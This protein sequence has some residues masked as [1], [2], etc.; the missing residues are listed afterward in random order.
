MRHTLTLT[1]R[2]FNKQNPKGDGEFYN[3]S[4]FVSTSQMK[5]FFLI[6]ASENVPVCITV[7]EKLMIYIHDV[8]S[9]ISY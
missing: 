2:T 7:D 3:K 4:H 1:L 6:F 8:P 9:L 5:V